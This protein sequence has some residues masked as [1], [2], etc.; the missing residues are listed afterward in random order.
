MSL[1]R[2]LGLLAAG[3]ISAA[4][5]A[6][7]E[8]SLVPSGTEYP[9][10]GRYN[11]DQVNS[12]IAMGQKYGYVVWEDNSS[13][14]QASGIAAQRITL[15]G[16]ERFPK[17]TVNR[18]TAGVQEKPQVSMLLNGGVVIV[19]QGGPQGKQ[20]IYA[21]FINELGKTKQTTDVLVN[22]HNTSH[23]TQAAV[24]VL[25]N[26][27]VVVTWNSL[28]Q[29]DFNSSIVNRRGLSG[30]FGQI[31]SPIGLKVGKE[32][33]VN[34][35]VAFGQRN[36]SVAVLADGFAAVWVTEK[37]IGSGRTETVRTVDINGR[38]FS[39][40][41]VPGGPEFR[42]N[43]TDATCAT[44]VVTADGNG[45]FT[46][47]WSQRDSEVP[48]HGW[49]VYARYFK[50]TNDPVG[51]AIRVNTYN[52]K[53]Q[54]LPQIASGKG[55]EFVV[56]TSQGQDGSQEGVFGQLLVKGVKSGNEFQ[57]NQ[58]ARSKQIH[59]SIAATTDGFVANWSSFTG[60]QNSLDI[61]AQKYNKA[62]E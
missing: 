40:V 8:F 24:A 55:G 62:A 6:H 28:G 36:S 48:Q 42:V 32:F 58:S 7:A 22:T 51:A 19:W 38:A 57:I 37:L 16:S 15:D 59:P 33:R 14:G 21:R 56:W 41:G 20:N 54:F 52:F 10:V 49:D 4:T 60:G 13:D 23:K 30:V 61:F 35:T 46:V 2:F 39:A 25:K 12:H 18:I 53:D 26:G 31:F 27:N 50:G 47:A 29:D 17:F 5:V 3:M 43:S 11:G 34:Q 1:S 44:P 9:I 45:G